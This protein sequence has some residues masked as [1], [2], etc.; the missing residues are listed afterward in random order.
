MQSAARQSVVDD[1]MA[2]AQ[3][4]R[5]QIAAEV[6]HRRAGLDPVAFHKERASGAGHENV[7]LPDECGEVARAGMADRDRGMPC[8]QEERDWLSDEAAAPNDDGV[9]A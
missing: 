6:D 5:S 9:G 3:E 1:G 7:R 4:L 2:L 8:Q